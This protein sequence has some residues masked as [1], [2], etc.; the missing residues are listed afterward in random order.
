MVTA[1]QVRVLQGYSHLSNRVLWPDY[2]TENGQSQG[3][4]NPS[5]SNL[6]FSK[7]EVGGV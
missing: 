6:L 5:S 7:E 3:S 2:V 4:G 1:E